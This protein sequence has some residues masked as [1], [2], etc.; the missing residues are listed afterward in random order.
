MITIQNDHIVFAGRE[1]LTPDYQLPL[2]RLERCP[3]CQREIIRVWFPLPDGVKQ[4]NPVRYEGL[5]K[6]K[7]YRSA[8]RTVLIPGYQG[9]VRRSLL[10]WADSNQVLC[11]GLNVFCSP[12]RLQNLRDLLRQCRYEF[13]LGEER[14][15]ILDL[16]EQL[17]DEQW[18]YLADEVLPQ[19]LGVPSPW[20]EIRA[21][22]EEVSGDSSSTL[23]LKQPEY[24]GEGADF[25]E[26]RD[27][28]G[29]QFAR[30]IRELVA[31]S[32]RLAREDRYA[33]IRPW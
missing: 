11:E 27:E 21:P 32:L 28:I 6:D 24:L 22:V 4:I 16:L 3:F 31:P 14:K 2:L 29:A 19:Y 5:P 30:F 10:H 15:P 26:W 33:Q 23:V 13:R 7:H 18:G 1:H 20:G 8:F 12:S 9:L 17:S 25:Y